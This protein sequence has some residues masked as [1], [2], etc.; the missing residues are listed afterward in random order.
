VYEFDQ[1]LQRACLAAGDAIIH[2]RYHIRKFV[3]DQ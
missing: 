3:S 2:F 1:F